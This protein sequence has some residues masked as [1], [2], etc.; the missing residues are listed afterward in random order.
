MF[1]QL[2]CLAGLT[3]LLGCEAAVIEPGPLAGF[4]GAP[5]YEATATSTNLILNAGCYRITFPGP[6][7]LT[8]SDSFATSGTVTI[9][10]YDA[11]IGQ[12]WRI[13]G[14]IVAD[15]MFFQLFVL[16][17]IT[18]NTWD[19]PYDEPLVAGEHATG[20]PTYCPI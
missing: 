1:N 6:V 8:P 3:L 4:W 17:A 9:S 5:H 15:T 14:E 11:Q 10:S 7:R 20:F 19:G 13:A 18:T 2:S 16:D 12:R